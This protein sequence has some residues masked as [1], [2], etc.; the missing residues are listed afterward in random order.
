MPKPGRQ[1]NRSAVGSPSKSFAAVSY[2]YPKG[3]QPFIRSAAPKLRGSSA[4]VTGRDYIGNLASTSTSTDNIYSVNAASS[5]TFPRL[6]VMSQ[7]FAQY[8]FTKLALRVVGDAA[9]TFSGSYTVSNDYQAG[10]VAMTGPQVRNQEGQTTK[11][12]WQDCVHKFDCAKALYDWY[13]LSSDAGDDT[14]GSQGT[15]GDLHVFTEAIS[16]SSFPSMDLFIEYECEFSQG[17]ANGAP[18]VDLLV[19][20]ANTM[21]GFRKFVQQAARAVLEP[22]V[23]AKLEKYQRSLQPR[24]GLVAE[25]PKDTQRLVRFLDQHSVVETTTRTSRL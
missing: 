12:F 22:E 13:Y 23:V 7:I 19:R 10:G 14:V 11:K 17:Q 15:M 20:K 9:S 2:A 4:C 25:P 18:E 16:G 5:G 3:L 21:P 24:L 8:K 6:S 1:V